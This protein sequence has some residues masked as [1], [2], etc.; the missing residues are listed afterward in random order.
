MPIRPYL[1]KHRFDSET[2]RVLGIAFETAL[3]ALRQAGVTDPS[4]DQVARIII[5]LAQTGE[6]DPD[7]L[8]E[9]VLTAL[10]T[11]GFC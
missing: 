7:C 5:E 1:D 3:V 9:A 6:R 11:T 8:C 10:R 2:I 4:R